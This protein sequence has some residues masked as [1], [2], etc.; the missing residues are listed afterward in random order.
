LA[1][2]SR[3]YET[4]AADGST[5]SRAQRDQGLVGVVVDDGGTAVSPR[6]ITYAEKTESI[7]FSQNTGIPS[8]RHQDLDAAL[9]S[10]ARTGSTRKGIPGVDKLFT[11]RALRRFANRIGSDATT[12]HGSGHDIS[13]DD[14]WRAAAL[15]AMTRLSA[16]APSFLLGC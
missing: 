7:Y 11:P 6:A 4:A 16:N 13:L 9:E 3:L 10:L 14:Q 2:L 12:V 1:I 15:T 8:P 5:I